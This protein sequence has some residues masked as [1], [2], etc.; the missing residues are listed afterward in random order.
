MARIGRLAREIDPTLLEP[1]VV[2]RVD[3]RSTVLVVHVV[4]VPGKFIPPLQLHVPN[5]PVQCSTLRGNVGAF[6][7]NDLE[8]H[9][10]QVASYTVRSAL[11]LM[12][13]ALT[14]GRANQQDAH[15]QEQ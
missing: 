3:S 9:L 15:T 2:L 6:K 1:A 5:M 10:S 13:S 11:T 4:D 14:I 8:N 7:A 12:I